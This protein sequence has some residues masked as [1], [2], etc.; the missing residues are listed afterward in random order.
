VDDETHGRHSR[1]PRAGRCPQIARSR[2]GQ[3]DTHT[4][5]GRHHV[6]PVG[7]GHLDEQR[8]VR[9]HVVQI[10][11]AKRKAVAEFHV[12][13]GLEPPKVVIADR[14]PVAELRD[15]ETTQFAAVKA[16]ARL[17]LQVLVD[18]GG[19]FLKIA[20]RIDRQE[21]ARAVR[22]NKVVQRQLKGLPGARL[23]RRG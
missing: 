1:Q 16:I 2:I 7:K 20:A 5:V 13:R 6:H 23:P 11:P 17:D 18:A 10:G 21:S 19:V 12:A 3:V 9:D 14:Q 8:P 15:V 4:A 22:G